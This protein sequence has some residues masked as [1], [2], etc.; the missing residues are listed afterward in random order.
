MC[1]FKVEFRLLFDSL[2]IFASMLNHL[3][4]DSLFFYQFPRSSF[5]HNFPLSHHYHLIIV[6]D[7]VD[8]M[9]DSDYCCINKFLPNHLLDECI[10]LHVNVRGCLVEDQKLISLEKGPCQA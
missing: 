7:C 4:E 3:K 9:S 1:S 10:C 5:L 6:C 8:P 2:S